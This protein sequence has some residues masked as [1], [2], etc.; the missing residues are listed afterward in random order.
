MANKTKSTKSSNKKVTFAQVR[1]D[2]AQRKGLDVTKASKRLRSKLRNAYD[3]DPVVTKYINR[4]KE[5]RDG[6]RYPDMTAAE[7]KHI[8]AL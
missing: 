3:K 8:V 6:N 1:I 2:Y 5:N 7:A 4:G